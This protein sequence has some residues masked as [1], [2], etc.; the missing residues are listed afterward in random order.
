MRNF[1]EK[2]IED[3]R[4]FADRSE[5]V[6][7]PLD[8]QMRGLQQTASGYGA[9]L[10]TAFKIMFEGKLRR[11]YSTCYGNAGSVWFKTKGRTIYVH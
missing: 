8:W 10:T 3:G 11:L 7:A 4:I 9:R 6:Y 2:D 5:L 1:T